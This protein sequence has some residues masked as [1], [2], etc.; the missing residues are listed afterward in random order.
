MTKFYL[1]RI[2]M[3]IIMAV[4]ICVGAASH[5]QTPSA[6]VPTSDSS[7]VQT[8]MQDTPSAAPKSDAPPSLSDY[9][10]NAGLVQDPAAPTIAAPNTAPADNGTVSIP[11]MEMNAL[12]GGPAMPPGGGAS[13]QMSEEAAKAS[14]AASIRKDAFGIAADQ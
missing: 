12:Q 10:N 7:S 5:A 8:L 3:V 4:L 11:T 6:A 2:Q 13:A 14:A 9:L 1:F